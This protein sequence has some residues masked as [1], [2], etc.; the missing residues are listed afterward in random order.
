VRVDLR[1]LD[2]VMR[3]NVVATLS[4]Y[5]VADDASLSRLRV[6]SLTDRAASEIETALEPFGH[7][8]PTVRVSV[9]FD[10]DRW[11]VE[12]DVDLGAPV[13]LRSVDVRV[14]GDGAADSAF[15]AALGVA[16]LEVDEPLSHVSYELTKLALGNAA[17]ERGYLDASFDSSTLRVDR[18]ARTADIVLHL[19][20]GPRFRLG[21]VRF[22]QD[23][24]N[25]SLLQELVPWEVGD[26]YEGAALR[27]LQAELSEGPY[28]SGVEIR[29]RREEA[30]DLIVP[31]D[32]SLTPRLSQG[33][34]LGG[35]YGTD[36]GPRV[37]F[38]AEFRRLN[39]SGHRAQLDAWVASIERRVTARYFVPPNGLQAALL[40][41]AAGFVD[42]NP[43]TS[44]T[45]TWLLSASLARPWGGWLQD[46]SLTLERASYEV[47]IQ[48]GISTLLI[49]GM[50][51]TRVRADDRIDPSRGSLLRV[52]TRG[53][54]D[55]IAGE[56]QFVDVGVEAR[57]VRLLVPRVRVLA[58]GE[59][60]ALFSPDFQSLPGSIRYFTGGSRTVRG[61]GYEEL[62]PRDSG[63][64][65]IG[66]RRLL[67]GSLEVEYRVAE[68]WGVAAFADAG[69]ASTNFDVPLEVGVG[70]GIR[71]RSPIG[72]LR[73]D[74][75]FAVS[76]PRAPFR[77]H[78]NLGPEL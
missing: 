45:Q 26:P 28:Y 19:Q 24:L 60:A 55:D 29:P 15:T 47:G 32:V 7:Y 57:I 18:P 44:D 67:V 4:V 3:D 78:F 72:M 23:A 39:R 6:Q 77:V 64:N 8:E 30:E 41:L 36:T 38:E 35:G 33:Y 16:P 2:D 20:T 46:L 27:A 37:T 52:R 59:A 42:S 71:W 68:A 70:M 1:G 13:V 31:L 34:A 48:S 17:A 49:L 56:A 51:L 69:N 9:Q 5:R 43:E 61:F 22:V 63:G 75:A 11:A 10:G 73:L 54:S 58:R 62:T 53:A 25:P 65:V 76:E 66:G 74:G 14:F 50:G 21:P 40:T 12:L